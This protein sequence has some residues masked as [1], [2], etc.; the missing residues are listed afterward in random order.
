MTKNEQNKNNMDN[1]FLHIKGCE[2]NYYDGV[3]SGFAIREHED[4]EAFYLNKADNMRHSDL[5]NYDGLSKKNREEL[6]KRW[7]AAKDLPDGKYDYYF[8]LEDKTEVFK[9]S[10]E[11]FAKKLGIRYELKIVD[12]E[13]ASISICLNDLTDKQ[14][15][16]FIEY[17]RTELSKNNDE[18]ESK[19]NG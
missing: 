3:F 12:D 16:N 2:I 7:E 19:R 17:L 9:E 6:A 8:N 10:V 15:E 5:G 11:A 13:D 18:S 4:V 14:R 1:K